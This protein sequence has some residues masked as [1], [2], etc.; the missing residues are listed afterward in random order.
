GAR[1][2][3]RMFNQNLIARFTGA[4]KNTIALSV[5]ALIAPMLA[6]TAVT[7]DAMGAFKLDDGPRQISELTATEGSPLVGRRVA[8]LVLEHGLVPL[9]HIPA[10]GP[11][12]LLRA[13]DS[14]ATL[15]VG[16]Q[17]VVCG[18][19]QALQ[20]LLGQLRG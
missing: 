2:V 18:T 3:V 9:A 15:A 7:G 5:S 19:P 20:K 11:P 17:L 16:D 13:V 4:V 10:I 1:V 14:D 8:D 12:R 6:L